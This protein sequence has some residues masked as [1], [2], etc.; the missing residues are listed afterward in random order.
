MTKEEIEGK[1]NKSKYRT[2]YTKRVKQFANV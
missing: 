1:H 2:K